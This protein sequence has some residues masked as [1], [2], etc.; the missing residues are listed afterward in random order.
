MVYKLDQVAN[1]MEHEVVHLP[2]YTAD[3]LIKLIWAQVKHY[4]AK[5][6]MIFRLANIEKLVHRAL[7]MSVQEHWMAYRTCEAYDIT[8][9]WGLQTS[10]DIAVRAYSYTLG[11]E[12]LKSKDDCVQ[13]TQK[14]KCK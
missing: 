9:S 8:R 11:W 12:M 2:L 13:E 1:E 7:N 3:S 14:Q 10:W 4:V 6:N 5:K